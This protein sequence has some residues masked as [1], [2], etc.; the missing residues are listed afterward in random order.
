MSVVAEI[1]ENLI[2]GKAPEVK[3]L[4]EKALAEGV[5]PADI[6]NNGMLAGMGT[7]GAR[8]KKNEVYANSFLWSERSLY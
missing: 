5:A 6:L 3:A 4:V 7:V 1:T 2:K 8:F